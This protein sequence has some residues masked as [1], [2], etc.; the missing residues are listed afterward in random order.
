MR[1]PWV[2]RKRLDAADAARIAAMQEI[3]KLQ[4]Q[5]RDCQAPPVSSEDFFALTKRHAFVQTVAEALRVENEQLKARVAEL[6]GAPPGSK[7][8]Q[9]GGPA[10]NILPIVAGKP[11]KNTGVL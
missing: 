5:L 3:I 2:R 6:H 10:S 8:I 11:P 9:I 7:T 4:A 1:W